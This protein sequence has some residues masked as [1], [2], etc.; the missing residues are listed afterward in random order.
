LAGGVNALF[1]EK[2]LI[3]G[4]KKNRFTEANG[5]NRGGIWRK[6]SGFRLVTPSSLF[7]PVEFRLSLL[8]A[9]PRIGAM[10]APARQTFALALTFGLLLLANGCSSFNREWEKAAANHKLPNS[11]EGR[12]EGKWLSDKNGHTGKL[13]CLL[14]RESDTNYHAHFKATYWKIF[15][16][17]YHVQFTGGMRDGVWNFHGDEDLGW[18]AGGVYHYKGRVT[19]TNF[20]STYRSEYDHG[21]FELYRPE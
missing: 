1:R 2:R 8:P 6:D 4:V 9:D 12:W 5:G 17:S 20:F 13:L 16:A 15:R 10:K 11:L 7:P 21:T 3:A 19:P 14:T 18:F